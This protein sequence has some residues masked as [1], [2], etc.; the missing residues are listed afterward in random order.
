VARD[1]GIVHVSR[2][3][4][5]FVESVAESCSS[6]ETSTLGAESTPWELPASVDQFVRAL[7]RCKLGSLQWIV[8][9]VMVAGSPT[10]S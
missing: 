1:R 5:V 10:L 6:S 3:F 9:S 2:S 7:T 4:T 8:E